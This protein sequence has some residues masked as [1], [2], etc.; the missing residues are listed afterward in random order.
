MSR[1]LGGLF[2][3]GGELMAAF[4]DKCVFCHEH[5]TQIYQNADVTYVISAELL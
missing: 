3:G 1:P 5:K 4:D 2:W